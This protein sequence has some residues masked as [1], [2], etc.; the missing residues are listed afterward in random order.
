MNEIYVAGVDSKKMTEMFAWCEEHFG[1]F[2][3]QW[4]Y[5]IMSGYWVFRRSEDATLF[6]LRW[7]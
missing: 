7:L 5:Y 4:N 6:A 1:E 3:D 2:R